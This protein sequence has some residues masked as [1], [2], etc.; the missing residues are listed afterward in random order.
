MDQS[1]LFLIIKVAAV[2]GWLGLLFTLERWRPKALDELRQPAPPNEGRFGWRRLLRN[3]TLWAG[4]L[5]LSPMV[6]LPVT[7]LAASLSPVVRPEFLQGWTGLVLDILILDMA[8]YWWHRFNHEVPFLW[9]FHEIHHLDERLDTTSAVR[10]HFG[11]VV[12]SAFARAVPVLAL[13]I[14]LTSVVVFELL[15]LISAIFQHSNIK[16][17]LKLERAL[18]RVLITPS[19]H[20]V[21]HHAKRA[22]TDSNYGTI[23]SIWDPIFGTR[24]ATERQV[25][26]RIGVEGLGDRP[27]KELLLRPFSRQHPP[28][29]NPAK[30]GAG[31]KE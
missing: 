5:L 13:G 20:W 8:I 4:N 26:M 21:H 30:A 10:F 14:P 9:R 22:D 17:P 24:S 1:T 19:I 28:S 16:L 7:A 23:L 31:E 25:D 15:V 27:L 18:S 6:V 2:F 11:E 3:G 12:L 29:L